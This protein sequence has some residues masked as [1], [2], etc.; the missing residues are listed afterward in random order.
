[1]LKGLLLRFNS[2]L[3]WRFLSKTNGRKLNTIKVS[4]K[5]YKS[6]ENQTFSI[7][8]RLSLLNIKDYLGGSSDWQDKKMK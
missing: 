2:H 6:I 4:Y 1:M 3:Q 8:I 7:K 5:K